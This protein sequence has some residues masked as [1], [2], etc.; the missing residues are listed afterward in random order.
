MATT[1]GK[2]RITPGVWL[3]TRDWAVA[4]LGDPRAGR[5][6]AG[7][8]PRRAGA[9]RPRTPHLVA[10]HTSHRLPGGSRHSAG[11]K[12]LPTAY[13]SEW[14]YIELYIL[15]IYPELDDGGL[16]YGLRV[17]AACREPRR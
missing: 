6:P 1:G 5:A 10:H 9:R 17:H 4:A 7:H 16:Q 12:P 14:N 15:R 11:M 13:T 2:R 3:S 8:G